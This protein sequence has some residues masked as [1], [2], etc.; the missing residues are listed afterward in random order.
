FIRSFFNHQKHQEQQAPTCNT[1]NS[2]NKHQRWRKWGRRAPNLQRGGQKRNPLAYISFPSPSEWR[3]ATQ[4]RHLRLPMHGTEPH[5]LPPCK[6]LTKT[7]K[8]M[9]TISGNLNQKL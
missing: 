6:P 3:R 5:L 1:L 7:Q 8:G 2:K 4:G 9:Y